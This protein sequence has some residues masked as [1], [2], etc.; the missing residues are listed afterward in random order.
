MKKV[1]SSN[2]IKKKNKKRVWSLVAIIS[3][4]VLVVAGLVTGLVFLLRTPDE[5]ES[6]LTPELE[7]FVEDLNNGNKN[8][9]DITEEII[10]LPTT[11]MPEKVIYIDNKYIVA[12]N[13]AGADE[14]YKRTANG[15]T[16]IQSFDNNGSP[17]T[18][19]EYVEI[20]GDYAYIKNGTLAE[21]Y[22]VN[23]KEETV[24]EILGSAV[25]SVNFVNDFAFKSELSPEDLN[26]RI[27][28]VTYL[29]NGENVL[30]LDSQ[31]GVKS[32]KFSNELVK[33]EYEDLIEYYSYEINAN[34][35][36][37]TY[38]LKLADYEN[39]DETYVAGDREIIV[40]NNGQ[41]V[42]V[43]ENN[44]I[45]TS[46]DSNLLVERTI[47]TTDYTKAQL[48]KKLISGEYYYTVSYYVVDL[49]SGSEKFVDFGGFLELKN[50]LFN[51]D[52]YYAYSLSPFN[53][54]DE[55]GELIEETDN[56]SRVIILDDEFNYVF[57]YNGL[58]KGDLV[59]F[60]GTHFV[61]SGDK[62][63]ILDINGNSTKIIDGD[64]YTI[65]TPNV[66]N[67]MFV[68]RSME[69]L[70]GVSDTKGNVVAYTEF[71]KI[72]PII[73]GGAIAYKNGH[74]YRLDLV[75]NKGYLIEDY[76]LDYDA[77]AFMGMGIYVTYSGDTY[78]IYDMQ[79]KQQYNDIE[80]IKVLN[81]DSVTNTL[82]LLISSADSNIIFKSTIVVAD[83][84]NMFI[85]GSYQAKA[86]DNSKTASV[87]LS[88]LNT[89]GIATFR[90]PSAEEL[91]INNFNG[92][93]NVSASN[94]AISSKIIYTAES[95]E[96]KA[97]LPILSGATVT[98]KE[99][100]VPALLYMPSTIEL[101]FTPNSFINGDYKNKVLTWNE[102][103]SSNGLGL[104]KNNSEMCKLLPVNTSGVIVTSTGTQLDGF[105]RDTNTFMGTLFFKYG[106]SL[107]I[108]IS[109]MN[110]GKN[111][112]SFYVGIAVQDGHTVNNLEAGPKQ[113]NNTY[114]ISFSGNVPDSSFSSS[115]RAITLD[116]DGEYI[117]NAGILA[118]SSGVNNVFHKVVSTHNSYHSVQGFTT[119]LNNGISVSGITFCADSTLVLS[120]ADYQGA[121]G[122]NTYIE[123]A[124]NGVSDLKTV[125]YD[126]N[127]KLSFSYSLSAPA[128]HMIF[129]G[130]GA[131]YYDD[132][133]GGDFD[134]EYRTKYFKATVYESY[135][136]EDHPQASTIR[137][138]LKIEVDNIYTGF[139]KSYI[140]EEYGSKENFINEL[141]KQETGNFH[142]KITPT[143]GY[144][145][146]EASIKGF[147]ANSKL[148]DADE[149]LAVVN[150]EVREDG[151]VDYFFS[152][153]DMETNGDIH[154]SWIVIGDWGDDD[155][156][157]E[158][159][160]W[161]ELKVSVAPVLYAINYNYYNDI[162][163]DVSSNELI[164]DSKKLYYGAAPLGVYESY[165]IISYYTRNL[166]SS[167]LDY[168]VSLGS[169]MYGLS[170]CGAMSASKFSELIF[171]DIDGYYLT[172]N[173]DTER[174]TFITTSKN[175]DT[176]PEDNNILFYRYLD[177]DHI[178]TNIKG[179]NEY[180]DL[181][182]PYLGGLSHNYGGNI[183]DVLV[184]ECEFFTNELAIDVFDVY[185]HYTPQKYNLS[186]N[187]GDLTD[188]DNKVKVI[189][190]DINGN[191][192][193]DDISYN[194]TSATNILNFTSTKTL[195]SI[196]YNTPNTI[197]GGYVTGG[198]G[199]VL[200]P[201]ITQETKA[202]DSEDLNNDGDKLSLSFKIYY[203]ET[204]LH[205]INR[206]FKDLYNNSSSDNAYYNFYEH[207]SL[208]GDLP[209]F[210][211][212][213]SIVTPDKLRQFFNFGILGSLERKIDKDTK[214]TGAC[215][216][217]VKLSD[218]SNFFE[219]GIE[220]NKNVS[221][222]TRTVFNTP[223][224]DNVKL[225]GSSVSSSDAG[226]ALTV[227][228]NQNLVRKH[229]NEIAPKNIFVTQLDAFN[230]LK[231][232]YKC[233][234]WNVLGADGIAIATMSGTTNFTYSNMKDLFT[235]MFD[236]IG[237]ETN[238][239]TYF[240]IVFYAQYDEHTPFDYEFK[241]N[242]ESYEFVEENADDEN[243]ENSE[244]SEQE[245][246]ISNFKYAVADYENMSALTESQYN[247][248]IE[249]GVMS[250]EQ[251]K[252][253]IIKFD[254]NPD[255]YL[256]GVQFETIFGSSRY[257]YN[258]VTAYSKQIVNYVSSWSIFDDDPELKFGSGT[259]YRRQTNTNYK[260]V[261][262]TSD[263]S[264]VVTCEET[265]DSEK[266]VTIR[267]YTVIIKNIGMGSL[268]TS[269]A[270]GGRIS[271][272]IYPREFETD[273]DNSQGNVQSF[274]TNN[275]DD[276][277][278]NKENVCMTV[279]N[280][281]IDKTR[282]IILNNLIFDKY[283]FKPFN[284]YKISFDN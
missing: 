54:Y 192:Y 172:P 59:Y 102:L 187:F 209:T 68:L 82:K 203:G 5:R 58:N 257:K 37:K 240:N 77:L 93:E 119:T 226:L 88:T 21:S 181:V 97:P 150:M 146:T 115:V 78:H 194:S 269:G 138:E 155:E 230:Y 166:E 86:I 206:H 19:N 135:R 13:S 246:I 253:I 233:E 228:T 128:T 6:L 95:E 85:E 282:N 202:P 176:I 191:K 264:Y 84:A 66:W 229:G 180:Y 89:V 266:G 111:I 47:P 183:Y 144:K 200:P 189:S 76:A 107:V 273:T 80:I 223:T 113:N 43:R 197:V 159:D 124:D 122:A 99:T 222:N 53:K 156:S 154:E 220:L 221:D 143:T 96:V 125:T 71:D 140:D 50:G 163:D 110:H 216:I 259:I 16:L 121:E 103:K 112:Y 160:D 25:Y 11:V 238:L 136:Y 213:V 60:D 73:G 130:K 153:D 254:L 8:D 65:D 218:Q 145:I 46:S 177:E 193:C 69:G 281:Y 40:D 247:P 167:L 23:L 210:I 169:L 219:W 248:Y 7:D 137:N 104:F 161:H 120:K 27:L 188:V 79:G 63:N 15:A 270:V 31:N 279:T 205:G 2:V 20:S 284:K 171:K 190:T 72:S 26:H 152:D 174:Y 158:M 48:T 14:I 151:T 118:D 42:V 30:N 129:E 242:G 87:E 32:I 28:N 234:G 70:F 123:Y 109:L 49:N 34:S 105:N 201:S 55:T 165:D 225:S 74:Y 45:L 75:N 275:C 179:D 250:I 36:T 134:K 22:I 90:K 217:L 52:N 164:Q 94:T 157:W 255:Y 67:N 239:D 148:F 24:V 237:A 232:I 258:D 214:C 83:I 18:Y 283:N 100:A 207:M 132:Y 204:L 162:H 184:G 268:T 265:Y 127:F 211:T 182:S 252:G 175:L 41:L 149:S 114:P 261:T 244:S 262:I 39:V 235:Y 133:S 108:A 241:I 38:S 141:M 256:G 51:V 57:D 227:Y 147:Y 9:Y 81:F 249:Q 243:A 117:T 62:S 91:H 236:G 3:A 173:M 231:Y 29:L 92:A 208:A 185:V 101:N 212:P 61:V 10:N 44:K 12:K 280:D 56:K 142:V 276:Y 98:I 196:Q 64:L 168:E 260:N 198:S 199:A 271:L 170:T 116:D 224:K 267:S 4:I 139:I 251:G 178:P 17:K 186:F 106:D 263:Q 33:V 245:E 274:T 126:Q 131:H 35:L 278:L 272:S 215:Y 1:N 277:V 195:N